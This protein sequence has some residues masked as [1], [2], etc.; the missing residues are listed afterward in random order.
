MTLRILLFVALA[1]C[2]GAPVSDTA[3]TGACD[4]TPALTWANFGQGWMDKHCVGCH[5][6]L[7]RDDQR[8]GAPPSV[9]LDTWDDAVFWGGRIGA[10]SLG[11]APTMPPGGG[12]SEE[13]RRLLAE[14]LDCA[15]TPAREAE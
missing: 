10:R 2:T 15:V 5:S 3:D 12:P 14:W 4:H 9:N 7:L 11:D 6:S 1:G 8:N 13:E